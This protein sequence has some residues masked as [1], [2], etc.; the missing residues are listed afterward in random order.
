VRYLRIAILLLMSILLPIRGAVASTM[1]CPEAAGTAAATVVAA[2]SHHDVH[3]EHEMRADD[4]ALHH[5]ASGV[6]SDD[7]S[8]SDEHPDTCHFCA[9]GCC[10]AAMVGTVPS[11]GQPGLTSSVRF[12]ALTA[13]VPA[14]QSGGQDRPPRT[15]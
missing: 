15:L 2:H 6:A 3:A 10:M 4:P 12:P 7:D 13:R 14:F 5:H 11:L 8:S 1:L 9:S